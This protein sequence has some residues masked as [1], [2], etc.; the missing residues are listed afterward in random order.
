MSVQEIIGQLATLSEGERDELRA[1]LAEID[2]TPAP[3][4]VDEATRRRG[5]AAMERLMNGLCR[6]GGRHLSVD[7][8]QAVYRA[9]R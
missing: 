7:I 6:G 3:T 9:D 4:P 5:L 8:D 1:A 2:L